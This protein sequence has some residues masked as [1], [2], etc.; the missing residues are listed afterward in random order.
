MDS[1]V[2]EEGPRDLGYAYHKVARYDADGG[3]LK[4]DVC[5]TPSASA[6][7][8]VRITVNSS[9]SVDPQRLVLNDPNDADAHL[10]EIDDHLKKLGLPPVLA[11][12]CA[13]DVVAL[14]KREAES[15]RAT[16]RDLESQGRR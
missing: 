16:Q 1:I 4:I 6:P 14:I 3:R 9:K 13:G 11:A 10:P 15:I 7:C 8:P 12:Y 2:W 5:V